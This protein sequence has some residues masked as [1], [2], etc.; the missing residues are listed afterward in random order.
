[1]SRLELH[2][3]HCGICGDEL[4][5]EIDERFVNWDYVSQIAH[6]YSLNRSA[7]YRHATGLFPK[8]DRNL[9]R[10]LGHIIH[11]A[12]R[13]TVTADAVVRAVKVFAHINAR[14]D[15]VN[16][17]TYGIFSSTAARRANAAPPR[18]PKLS[19]TPSHLKRGPKR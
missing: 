5:E 4:Q 3:A 2:Q 11:E 10:A 7:L 17:P 16:P 15:W 6:D 9:R 13:V 1:M 19:G 12:G 8:R 14:G 18:S